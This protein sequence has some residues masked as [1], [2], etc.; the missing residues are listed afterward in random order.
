MAEITVYDARELDRE[1][2]LDLQ[3]IQR[4][5][6][7]QGM[8]R[9]RE[10]T[11]ELVSWRDSTRYHHSHTD[12]NVEVGL[13]FSDGQAFSKPRVAVATE[14]G[15]PVGFAYAANNVSGQSALERAA[16]RLTVVK[17]YFWLREIAVHPAGQGLGIARELGTAILGT[18]M[19]LQRPVAYTWPSEMPA[20]HRRLGLIGFEDTG[21]ELVDLYGTGEQIRQVRMQAHSAGDVLSK[22]GVPRL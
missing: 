17:N 11:D 2:W 6:L 20:L 18:A 12:P 4:E 19:P 15:E 22:I 21:E 3:L 10:E 9:D 5:A 8:S 14:L 1:D 7:F 16:K 13:R